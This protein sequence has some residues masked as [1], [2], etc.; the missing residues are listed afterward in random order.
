[1]TNAAK[2][3]RTNDV[4][5][6]D[7]RRRFFGGIERLGSF[8]W[9]H[10]PLSARRL[11]IGATVAL[12]DGLY[13]TIQPLIA[14]LAPLLTLLLGLYIGWS[15]WGFQVVFTESLAVMVFA[16]L[17]GILSAHLGLL[18]L[19]GFAFGD[20]FLAVTA[21]RCFS[22][23][24]GGICADGLISQV[25]RVRIPLIIEYGLLGLLTVNV[26]IL[27]KTLLGHL[28]PPP[29]FSRAVSIGLAMIGHAV[30]TG[31][32]V[33]FWVQAVPILIRP[34]F[35]WRGDSPPVQAIAVLQQRGM[36]LVYVA[37]IASV[38]RMMVQSLTVIRP[39]FR[40]RIDAIE[41]A[42]FSVP[43]VTPITQYLHPWIRTA[44][45]AIWSTLLISGMVFLWYDA[46]LL[47]ILIFLLQAA[48][49]RLIPVPLGR[50]PLLV[51]RIPLLVRMVIGSLVIFYL[52]RSFLEAQM[53]VTNSFRPV[54]L[55][56][57]ISLIIF[58]LLNPGLPAPTSQ[59]RV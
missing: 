3:P 36:I 14:A 22:G 41:E 49:A 4:V 18:F 44:G 2:T 7:Q 29:R 46:V 11:S 52:A 37:L 39:H 50:W 57:G 12:L 10:L 1:M 26:P 15:H 43:A 5:S 38:V 53:R 25:T 31:I 55:L 47:G 20:F 24:F 28:V 17:L 9:I 35:S 8:W 51:Q 13:I 21:W 23:F 40:A 54:V 32:L 6:G 30:I 48:R 33:F 19:C 27:T 16:T 45:Q 56:T 59:E 42:L 34:V 58:F